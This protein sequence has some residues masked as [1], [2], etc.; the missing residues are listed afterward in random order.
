MG[1]VLS[2]RK[3][4]IMSLANK[5]CVPCQGGVPPLS[6]E[7]VTH[8]LA[9]IEP[10]WTINEFGHLQRDFPF[11]NFVGAVD[12]ANHLT[13]IAEQEGHHPDLHLTWGRCIVELWTHKINGLTE[14]DFIFAAKCDE[15]YKEVKNNKG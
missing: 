5:A 1:R 10:G 8:L 6:K 2:A 13:K 15:A 4:T 7:K 14:S 12:F 3:D 9:Q 11:K